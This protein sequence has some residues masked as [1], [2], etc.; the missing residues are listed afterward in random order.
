MM[1]IAAQAAKGKTMV[2]MT[3]HL[4]PLPGWLHHLGRGIQNHGKNTL[5]GARIL[6]PG[7]SI[8]HA[9]LLI[10]NNHAPVSAYRHV[11]ADFPNALKERPFMLLDHFISIN[12]AF[13]HKIGGFWEKAGKFL[14]MDICLQADTFNTSKNSCMYLP[15]V[16][17]V[18]L[19][20]KDDAF[21]PDDAA[22]FY[23]RW[24]GH[25]W[26]NQEIFYAEDQVSKIDLD[27]ARLTQ[28][29]ASADFLE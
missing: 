16:C 26:E 14:F 21:I 13:F 23:G 7:N 22:W 24:H 3:G 19:D 11:A 2:F 9:G 15:D 28:S 27:A 25:L 6:T 4:M 8:H 5:M 12:H 20:T 29:M 1:N 18:A 17:L 10:D